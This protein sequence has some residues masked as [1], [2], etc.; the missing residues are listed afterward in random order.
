MVQCVK[1]CAK[2][3][4]HKPNT[5]PTKSP[6]S[7][8]FPMPGANPFKVIMVDFITKLP[9][10]Q[11]G[12]GRGNPLVFFSKPYP[13]PWKPLPSLRDRGSVMVEIKVLKG[14]KGFENP[15]GYCEGYTLAKTFLC[16]YGKQAEYNNYAMLLMESQ[17][18]ASSLSSF[19]TS[20]SIA[21]ALISLSLTNPIQPHSPRHIRAC[22]YWMESQEWRCDSRICTL[23]R[24][25]STFTDV[26]D[27]NDLVNFKTLCYEWR[28]N[29][30]GIER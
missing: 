1:G 13:Y 12:I 6:L 18:A 3:Q 9:K 17:L 5:R 19:W 26:D 21:T 7:A 27:K 22:V 28:E 25:H 23:L 15:W 2:C 30:P 11:L 10:S 29:R 20:E 24:T 8:I 16:I 14:T 4:Q